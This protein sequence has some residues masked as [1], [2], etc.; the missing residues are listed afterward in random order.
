MRILIASLL[1]TPK[2]RL[3]KKTTIVYH[4]TMMIPFHLVVEV[5]GNYDSM[6]L[7]RTSYPFPGWQSAD[8]NCETKGWVKPFQ[9]DPLSWRN[10]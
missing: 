8:P 2:A 5:L 9:V 1:A 7:P 3:D 10:A 4:T 6:F